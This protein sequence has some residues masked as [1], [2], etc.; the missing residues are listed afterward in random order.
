MTREVIFEAYRGGIWWR[1]L[2]CKALCHTWTKI[3]SVQ[4]GQMEN[5]DVSMDVWQCV[6]CKVNWLY[7]CKEAKVMEMK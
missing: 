3:I 5:Y 7:I 2:V 4:I 6:D 1:K